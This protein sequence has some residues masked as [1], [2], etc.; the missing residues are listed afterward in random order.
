MAM[1][2]LLTCFAVLLLAI[3][4]A[5]SGERG[6]S[7]SLSLE[8]VA[9]SDA[10]LSQSADIALV[11]E[12]VACVIDSFEVQIHCR[13]R[14][15]LIV[16]V[17]GSEGDGPGEFRGLSVVER[18]PNG[19]LAAIDHELGRTTLFEPFGARLSETS[20]PSGFVPHK[21]MGNR[22][23]GVDFSATYASRSPGGPIDF[24]IAEVDLSSGGVLWTRTGLSEIVGTEC[25]TVGQGWPRPRGGYVFWACASELVFLDH[26]DAGSATV[27]ISP[28]YFEE[29]PNE[30][31][32]RDYLTSIRSLGGDVS[33]PES[34]TDAYLRDFRS[35]PKQWHLASTT[36]LGFDSQGRLWVGTT[37]DRDTYSYLD[38]WAGTEYVKTVRI[39]DRLIGYDLLGGTLAALVERA[40]GREGIARRAID[41]Y[42]IDRLDVG[43]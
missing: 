27:V 20:M 2:I 41:W 3:A 18:G 34:M 25:G 14:R 12:G 31:D 5:C 22:L 4:V 33:L 16:G 26:K 28:T 15:N 24:V 8:P 39:R 11:S 17:F 42:S 37:R 36:A 32:A 23:F 30:R 6:S 35:K 13:D 7:S 29:L 10:P 9:S 19:T 21:L 38:I 43:S 40:P 1:R